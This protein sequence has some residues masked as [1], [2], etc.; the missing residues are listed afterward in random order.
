MIPIPATWYAI[1]AL[2][3]SN[4]F[5]G[6]MW[7][8]DAHKLEIVKLTSEVAAAAS[9]ATIK[10]Q[11]QI[12]EDTKNGWKAALDVT[13]DSWAKRLRLANVQPMSGISGPTGGVD[14]LP[15]DSLALA[16]RCAETTLQLKTLQNWVHRQGSVR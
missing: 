3:L 10:A 9:E 14:G 2:A 8:Q 13:N 5:T 16:A 1:A 12:T 4:L 6:Y 15:T 11:K 7:Q